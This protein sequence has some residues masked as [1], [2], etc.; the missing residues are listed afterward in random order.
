MQRRRRR[1]GG[2]V[3]GAVLAAIALLAIPPAT[4]SQQ[5]GAALVPPASNLQQGPL[6]TDAV[7]APDKS[8]ADAQDS[9]NPGGNTSQQ[10]P[11]QQTGGQSSGAP[12]P[13]AADNQKRR[14]AVNPVTGL[15]ISP[16]SN[17]T[18]LTGEERWKLYWKQ[19]FFSVGAYFRPAFFAL[20]LDQTTSS[21]PQWGDGFGG[22][23]IRVASRAACVGAA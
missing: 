6:K 4:W 23:G 14:L 12:A 3:L 19:N 22:F 10:P 2:S 11:A 9:K 15:T 1:K 18:P 5:A 8:S 21:P 7:P 17:F 16:A 13:S 20:A